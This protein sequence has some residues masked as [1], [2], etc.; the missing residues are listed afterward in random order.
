MKGTA[1]PFADPDFM[2]AEEQI[3]GG[4]H[5]AIE[6][7][8]EL[9]QIPTVNPPGSHYLE[10]ALLL[11]ERLRDLGFEPQTVELPHHERERL[12]LSVDNPHPSVIAVLEPG[13]APAMLPTLHFHGH[14]DV[15]PAPSPELFRLTS[16]GDRAFGRGTADMKG[17]IVA[18]LLA[19]AA[20]RPL[21]ERLRGRVL[22]S[23][24]PDEE[25]GG[26]AG[27]A[28]LFR[29]GVLVPGGLGMLMPEPAGAVVW[30]GNR[31]AVSLLLT[32]H[33]KSAHVAVQHRGVNAF[34][35]MLELGGLLRD[36]KQKVE[37]R[38]FGEDSLGL[39]GPPSVL[40]IGG[41]CHGG[42]NF[43]VVP[44]EAQ[45]SIDRRFHAQESQAGVEKELDG[46]FRGFR[47]K[48]WK[49]EV[50]QLQR[51]AASLTPPDSPFARALAT[52]VSEVTGH[53][54][55]FTLCPGI[56]ETR[57]FLQHG[58]PGM[59]YGP[60]ELEFSHQANEQVSLARILEVARVYA[61]MAWMMVGP[62]PAS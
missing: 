46:V 13:G 14:Y 38:T 29:T 41:V 37:L 15:V 21:R 47:R 1:D 26:E 48:G 12:G 61:R 11:A 3:R 62:G 51:G 7:L 34:E 10:C 54:A 6:L 2:K 23:L 35:G 40:L 22:L 58:I 17:G 50:A 55:R 9:V 27:T 32:V 49:L 20:L 36:L 42:T 33:G 39:E 31:G 44:H 60:G 56:L 24:V 53:A 59:A 8:E 57:F 16:S 30:N 25:T 43:N 18:M 5:S 45:F 28:H 4:R 52:V 19:L